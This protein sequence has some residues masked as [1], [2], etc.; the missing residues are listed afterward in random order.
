MSWSEGKET[1]SEMGG[2]LALL[3]DSL[4]QGL[5]SDHLGTDSNWWTGGR[6]STS[7]PK[8]WQWIDGMHDINYC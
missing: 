1:C 7:T 8:D 4:K 5:V 3:D 6:R 2:W